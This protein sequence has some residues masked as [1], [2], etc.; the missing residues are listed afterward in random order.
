MRTKFGLEFYFVNRWFPRVFLLE[1]A[2]PC[3]NF[4]LNRFKRHVF[5]SIDALMVHLRVAEEREFGRGC[6]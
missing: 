2:F 4:G 3:L 6:G 5:G 1:R